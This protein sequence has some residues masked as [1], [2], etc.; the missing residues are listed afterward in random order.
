MQYD[1]RNMQYGI[2]RIRMYPLGMQY[3]P[4]N[5]IGTYLLACLFLTIK[6]AGSLRRR[7]DKICK[8]IFK[9][10]NA[11][12]TKEY[13]TLFCC[14]PN[15]ARI[16]TCLDSAYSAYVCT[17]HSADA[18]AA[19]EWCSSGATVVQQQRC[20]SGAAAVHWQQRCSSGASAVQQRCKCGAAAVQQ[21]CSSGATA[22]Q[23]RC[24]CCSSCAAAAAP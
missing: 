5:K 17:S 8:I 3:M 14:M 24:S 4:Y 21:R 22:V 11:K 2:C 23:Q 7:W 10:K 19:Q 15:Y 18:T 16:V 20:S 12:N 9:N 1:M 6:K 13:V